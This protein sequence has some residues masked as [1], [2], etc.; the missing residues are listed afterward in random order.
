M[1]LYLPRSLPLEEL[2]VIQCDLLKAVSDRPPV[3]L[4]S[5]LIPKPA[6]SAFVDDFVKPGLVGKQSVRLALQFDPRSLDLIFRTLE[7]DE[8]ADPVNLPLE[9]TIRLLGRVHS[10]NR[11]SSRHERKFPRYGRNNWLVV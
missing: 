1:G 11:A 10:P 3:S 7:K 8:G 9:G 2:A 5:K 6:E 4:C